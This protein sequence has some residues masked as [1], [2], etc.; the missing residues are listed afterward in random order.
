MTVE[1]AR[2]MLTA[3]GG[4]Q[5]FIPSFKKNLLFKELS[6]GLQKTLSKIAVSSDNHYVSNMARLGLFDEMLL[7]GTHEY[8][9]GQLTIVD[10]IAFIAQLKRASNDS[11]ILNFDARC[12]CGNVVKIV[13]DLDKVLENCKKYDFKRL[14]SKFSLD[15]KEYEIELKDA[16][17]MDL[18]I[19]QESLKNTYNDFNGSDLQFQIYYALNKICMYIASIKINGDEVKD[20]NEQPF[21][22][23][24]VPD[25]I[26][27]FDLLNP[28]ITIDEEVSDSLINIVVQ[29]FKDREL[30][31]FIFTDTFQ[32]K[33]CGACGANVEGVFTYD[34]FF[35]F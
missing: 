14:I 11:K 23:W 17:W 27:F 28:K 16:S 22:K 15:G 32:N 25:R 10:M 12:S 13:I 24:D 19:L 30:S 4:Q 34:N 7:E 26:K 31:A 5:F 18:I 3:G 2:K 29:N 20:K 8:K 21:D 33:T 35:D 9:S 1:E 6:T